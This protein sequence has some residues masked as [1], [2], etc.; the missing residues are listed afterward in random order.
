MCLFYNTK[1]YTGFEAPSEAG[2]FDLPA[3]NADRR[4]VCWDA[5]LR[6]I[7]SDVM[8]PAIL[9]EE[10]GFYRISIQNIIWI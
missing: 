7:L 2:S 3:L 9:S 10:Y 8:S 1:G 6:T 5:I 4:R